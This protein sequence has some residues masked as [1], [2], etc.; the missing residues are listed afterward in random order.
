M[1]GAVLPALI[2][3]LW[4]LFL[5]GKPMDELSLLGAILFVGIV[6]NNGIVLVD[7]VQQWR[8]AGLP[9]A[10]AI[11]TAGRD[12]VRPVVMTALTTIA[13]LLPMALF[14]GAQDE[15]Q[16]D[17]LATAVIGGLV[18]STIVTLLFVPV[19]FSLLVDLGRTL[20]R[21]PR[22]IARVFGAPRSESLHTPG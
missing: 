5:A 4:A 19:L 7:R 18:A 22:T 6:V 10:T 9:L 20:R 12:R 3:G 21:V 16:Y 17:T 8:R 11:R 14:K 2:G 1:I 13:G 15:I